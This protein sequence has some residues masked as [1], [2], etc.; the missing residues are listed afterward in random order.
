M[1]K[2]PFCSEEIQDQ[3]VKCKHCKSNLSEIH[4]EENLPTGVPRCQLCKGEMKKSKEAANHTG[5]C[6]LIL[7]SAVALCFFP[8]G[9][10]IGVFLLILGLHEATKVKGLWICKN[11]GHQMERKRS[12][13]E[14]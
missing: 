9:T 6:L 7:L 5:G 3:A 12:W 10:I 14:W 8:I 4:G 1:K 2:C 11:C 13:N